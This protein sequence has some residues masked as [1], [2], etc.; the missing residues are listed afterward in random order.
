MLFLLLESHVPLDHFT[1]ESDRIDAVSLSPKM[2]APIRLLTQT[3]KHIEQ[4]NRGT[5][6]QDTHQLRDRQLRRHLHQQVHVVN[7]H[8]HFHDLASK[9]L[10]KRH[11]A[12]L[13]LPADRTLQHPEPI[14]RHP[15]QMILTM[16]DNM[17][18][19]FEP[20]HA[21]FLSQRCGDNTAKSTC[22]SRRSNRQS[23]LG[24][25]RVLRTRISS[26]Y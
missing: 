8:V 1:V 20:A 13:H 7:L 26:C 18:C 5:S 11:H 16:P 2:I 9:L 14:L 15:H 4:P 12:S 3:W 10:A 6:F 24:D 17:R 21:R 19:S 22:M 25:D 23:Q